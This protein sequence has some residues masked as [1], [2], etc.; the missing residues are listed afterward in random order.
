M[1]LTIR[2]Y[3]PS[4]LEPIVALINAA[5]NFDKTEQGTS[6]EEMQG[7]LNTPGFEPERNYFVA[8]D[9]E[10]RVVG[11]AN[12]HLAQE[13]H[14][15]SFRT[16][17]VVHPI[18]RG[19]GLEQRLL[20]QLYTRAEER[21]GE[22]TTSIVNFDAI[23]NALEAEAIV[24]L[25]KF[26]MS[27][28]RHLWLMVRPDLQNISEP[29]FAPNLKTRSYRIKE[30]D[31]A[32][33]ATDTEV[34]RDHWGH[35]DEPLERWQHYVAWSAFRPDL[36]VIAEDATTHEIAGYCMIVV[37]EE[38][39]KRLSVKRGWIDIL[40]VR[41]PYRNQGLGTSLLL[42]GLQNLRD[43][44]LQQA[45]LG[46]D[47]ENLT[48]ATRIYERVGFQVSKTQFV[49][50]KPMRTQAHSKSQRIALHETSTA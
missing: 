2:N 33:H 3:R 29:Q 24:A 31:V 28:A 32:M 15:N 22:C 4:D 9:S 17:F 5:A 34:F 21:L 13:P 6:V 50:R 10:G 41:R 12:L 35:A 14:E 25:G 39:H 7:W 45:A 8:E 11:Y 26:G 47:S 16:R 30:D 43:A 40:G 48:G 42:A 27:N 19:R 20:T 46:C 37:N 23:V 49:Y 1:P 38:E 36:T 18:R 44:G